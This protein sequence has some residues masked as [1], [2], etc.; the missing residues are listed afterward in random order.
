MNGTGKAQSDDTIKKQMQR[1]ES[2]G[3]LRKTNRG[4]W[5]LR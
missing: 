3:V 1:V 2:L 5:S 4:T